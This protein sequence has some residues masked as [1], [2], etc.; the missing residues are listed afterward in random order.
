MSE[1]FWSVFSSIIISFQ[2][3]KS[4]FA[5]F[6]DIFCILLWQ[7]HA[8]PLPRLLSN[9]ILREMVS[10]AGDAQGKVRRPLCPFLG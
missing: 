10:V 9:F 7:K 1:F 2:I 6:T 8:Y 3:D 5:T 4:Q